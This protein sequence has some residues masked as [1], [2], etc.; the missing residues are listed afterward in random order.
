MK[1]NVAYFQKLCKAFNIVCIQEHWLWEFQ[2]QEISKLS[3]EK[4]FI[5]H[6]SDYLEPITGDRLPRGKGGVCILWP[7]EWSSKVKRLNDGNER[8]V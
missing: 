1:S 6:C 8:V 2:S 3:S 5:I 4:D 7:K